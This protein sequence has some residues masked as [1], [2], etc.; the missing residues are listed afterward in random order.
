MDFIDGFR[1]II[2]DV[3]PEMWAM[4]HAKPWL[5][6]NA[7]HIFGRCFRSRNI[8]LHF[9]SVVLCVRIFKLNVRLSNAQASTRPP[10]L[11]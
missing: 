3:D 1:F 7:A 11:L 10:L 5:M 8:I 9:L 4:G 6:A 2:I